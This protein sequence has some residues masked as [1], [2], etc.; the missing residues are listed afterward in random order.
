M[1][2]GSYKGKSTSYLACGKAPVFAVDQWDS[3]KGNP[4]Y[5]DPQTFRDF[6]SNTNGLNVTPLKGG[7]LDIARFWTRPIGLLFI[8][9][10][11]G[12]DDVFRDYKAWS[13]F[14]TG[15]IAFHDYDP[16]CKNFNF[17]GVFKVVEEIV[18]PSGLWTDYEVV[19]TIFCARML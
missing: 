9:A 13:P 19:G 16:E 6:L 12:F 11:H 17:N 14:V 3:A 5:N 2:L 1:E 4:T 15:Y 7:T 18:K 8:D 10:G